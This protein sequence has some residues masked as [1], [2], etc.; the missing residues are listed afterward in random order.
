[1][2]H[3]RQC[4]QPG[5][6]LRFPAP[7][8]TP[9]GFACP[10]C[11]SPT[12]FVLKVPAAAPT[13]LQPP[14]GPEVEVLL[15]NIRSAWNVGSMLRSADGAGVRRVHFLGISPTPDNPK[16]SKTALG[17]EVS[18]PWTY[19]ADGLKATQALK[20]S[21]FRLWALESGLA[22]SSLFQAVQE[23]DSRPVGLVVGN[24]LTGI[25]PEIV[26]TCERVVSIPMSGYKRSLNVAIAFGI[27]VY[28]LRFSS[29]L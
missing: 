3:I 14:T 8:A 12:R 6:G 5:C 27:A 28:L 13:N 21:G 10:H 7:D 17:A 4:T 25:D 19:H 24:E 11:G 15:D 18:V 26:S 23:L 1:M 9:E 16:T 29:S 22:S 20:A 2:P